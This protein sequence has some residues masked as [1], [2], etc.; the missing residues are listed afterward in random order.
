[1][2][3]LLIK[4]DAWCYV[5][6]EKTKPANAEE[7]EEDVKRWEISDRKARSDI[8][9]SINPSELN[10]IKGCNTSKEVWE[11]LSSIYESKGPARKA[12][13]LKLLMLHRM[14]DSD[15]VREHMR[16]FFDTVDKLSDMDVDINKDLLCVMLLYS[17]APRFENF[18]CA[19]ESRDELP[20][21]ETLR[22]KIVEERR[23][24]K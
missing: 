9:L 1:M 7:N 24:E 3:A 20:S 8:I 19:I 5:S 15:D 17:L 4:N 23:Q 18:R 13:L 6:G 21:P 10:Q 22:I 16:K 11:K 14:D 2:E 12:S